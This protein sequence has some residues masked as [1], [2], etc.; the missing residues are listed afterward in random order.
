MIT[1]SA[2]LLAVGEALE[3]TLSQKPSSV[4]AFS[5]PVP[6]SK[7]QL[8]RRSF[9]K[10]KQM[11]TD[12]YRDFATYMTSTTAEATA[13]PIRNLRHLGRVS[14]FN[15]FEFAQMG[16][17]NGIDTRLVY[18]VDDVYFRPGSMIPDFAEVEVEIIEGL[19]DELPLRREGTLNTAGLR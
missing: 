15:A 18:S 10:T 8:V 17:V 1:H 14:R 6:T 9:S 11:A 5:P 4:I 7:A 13:H 19:H 3:L 2:G 12:N 16:R